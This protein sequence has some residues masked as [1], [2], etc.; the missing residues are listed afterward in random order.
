M[1]TFKEQQGREMEQMRELITGLSRQVFHIASNS[2]GSEEG[3]SGNPNHSLLR[4]ARVEFPKFLGEDVQGWIYKCDQFFE[5]DNVDEDVKVRI[6]SIHLSERA[7]QWHQSFMKS[8]SGREWP[9]WA[10]YKGVIT[11]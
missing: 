6:A 8:R 5:I 4:L 7:L 2:G 3:S 10:E 11:K 9:L 1:E